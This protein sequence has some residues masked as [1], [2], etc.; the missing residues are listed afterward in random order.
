MP[1]SLQSPADIV[2]A[3]LA[4][5]GFKDR[6]GNL[7][8]GS[9]AAKNA[10]DI[11]AQTRD[12]LLRDGEWP[13]A[14]RDLVAVLSKSA[15]AGGYSVGTPWDPTTYPP[16]P[17]LFQY[18]WPDDCL[19]VRTIKTG[20]IA[21]PNFNPQPNLFAVLNN[22]GARSIVSNIASAVLT[23]VGQ[24]TDPTQMPADFLEAFVA[25]LGRRMAPLLANL[26]AAKLEAQD[27]QVE[28]AMASRQQG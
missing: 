12:T 4:R 24:I 20:Y 18:A 14:Q 27:E 11:Y 10:L 19:R 8:E 2:N 15:P 9:R 1:A 28:T 16:L 21:V 5:I 7:Y 17:W 3:S 26:D 13:F 23:Y 6:V 22:G 25:A